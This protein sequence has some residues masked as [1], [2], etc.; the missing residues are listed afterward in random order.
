M[1]P[2]EAMLGERIANFIGEAT[3]SKSSKLGLANAEQY[4]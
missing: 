1:N 2:A 4:P 3:L